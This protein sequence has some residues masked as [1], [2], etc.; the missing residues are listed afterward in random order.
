LPA[1]V[2]GSGVQTAIPRIIRGGDTDAIRQRVDDIR[3]APDAVRHVY[4]VTSS[5]SKAQVQA[6]FENLANGGRPPA[7]F[8][9]LYWLLMAYFSACSE[10]GAVGFVVC[11]P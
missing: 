3:E 4:I 6:E 11:R 8:V 9:Q 2:S 1:Y 7:H 5:L 10:M